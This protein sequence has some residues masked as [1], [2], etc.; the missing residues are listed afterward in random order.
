MKYVK[1]EEGSVAF[2]VY[3][4]PVSEYFAGKGLS[5]LCVNAFCNLDY[6]LADKW[7]VE[8]IRPLTLAAGA[9]YCNFKYRPKSKKKE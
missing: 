7:G 6:P 8:L 1:T 4:C 9:A 3:R 5:E 2:D